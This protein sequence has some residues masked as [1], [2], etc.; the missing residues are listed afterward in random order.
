MLPTFETYY[1]NT[2][3]NALKFYMDKITIWYSYQTVIAFSTPATGR[4]ISANH[5]TK[6]TGR[7]LNAIDH[8][9]SLRVKDYADFTAQLTAAMAG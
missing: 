6:T 8:D 1:G 7:R 3:A 4:V 2:N 5:W 9:K